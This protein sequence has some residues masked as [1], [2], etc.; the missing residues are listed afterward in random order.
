MSVSIHREI[1]PQK[2]INLNY[3]I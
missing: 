2:I 1:K 3:H